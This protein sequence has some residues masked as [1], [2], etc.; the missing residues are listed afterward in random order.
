[1]MKSEKTKRKVSFSFEDNSERTE[2]FSHICKELNLDVRATKKKVGVKTSIGIQHIFDL[3]RQNALVVSFNFDDKASSIIYSPIEAEIISET[4]VDK[5]DNFEKDDV[6][7]KIVKP[8]TEDP[9]PQVK[10]HVLEED[11]IE[12]EEQNQEKEIQELSDD[13][14]D[15]GLESNY[16]EEESEGEIDTD[17][18]FEDD[19]FNEEDD[20]LN[21]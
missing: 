10:S 17:L 12:S 3:C 2:V 13:D 21:F 1:M 20:D 5:I 18:D 16:E 9:I 15:L 8:M 11:K 19:D 4:I 14:L 6:Q 7:R